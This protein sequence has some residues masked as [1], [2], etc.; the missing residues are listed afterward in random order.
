MRPPRPPLLPLLPLLLACEPADDPRAVAASFWDAARRGQVE[1]AAELVS[2][3]S[4]AAVSDPGTDG[5]GITRVT[6]GDLE[7]AGGGTTV[8]TTMVNSWAG[9]SREIVFTTRLVRELGRWRVDL[10]AT[11]D[12]IVRS[13]TPPKWLGLPRTAV[14]MLGD[15]VMA[16][17][18][19][20]VR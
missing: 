16:R 7:V 18:T 20:T 17:D 11:A 2:A 15:T 10:D 3:T 13:M 5:S 14:P 8:E 6:L 12:E 9:A 4:V 1:R 19:A